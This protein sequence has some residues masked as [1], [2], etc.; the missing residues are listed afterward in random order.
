MIYSNAALLH[1][2]GLRQSAGGL[3]LQVS[4]QTTL[5]GHTDLG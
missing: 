3:R 2:R 5:D 1:G 4:L